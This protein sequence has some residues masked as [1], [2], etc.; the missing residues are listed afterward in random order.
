[1]P[2]T[3]ISTSV[4]QL[5]SALPFATPKV[6]PGDVWLVGAGP[7][8][9]GLL[10]LNA[11]SVLGQAD[12][13][14]HD[15]LI[16]PLLLQMVPETCEIETVGK[17]G[18]R[19]SAKQDDINT[20]LVTEARL[21]KRV[22]RLKGGDPF[23]FGR[24][25]EEALTLVQENIPVRVVPGISAATGGLALAGIPLTHRTTNSAVTLLT[26]RDKTGVL[27]ETLDWQALAQ[28]SPAIVA[29][30]GLAKIEEIAQ[31]LIAAGRPAEDP[32]AVVSH[33]THADQASVI[34]T[35]AHCAEDIA[36]ANLQ[37]PA[38]IVI[39]VVAPLAH[40]LAPSLGQSLPD[41]APAPP[42]SFQRSS[43]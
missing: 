15:A 1:M 40:Q 29:F 6:Q 28:G 4:T 13:V 21:Q 9:P 10:T 39:G 12:I 22:I 43:S 36:K 41:Y 20:R 27:P 7:G 19:L 35:L 16:D 14:L 32:V 30:M 25:A 38:L 24:G 37:A 26:A 23:L 42:L 2:L 5:L 34:T 8:H 11:L 18:G 33:A 17:R 3:S 31:K